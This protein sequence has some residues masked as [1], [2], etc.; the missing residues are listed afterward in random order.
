MSAIPRDPLIDYARRNWSS[1]SRVGDLANLFMRVI[2][3]SWAPV[4]AKLD[5]HLQWLAEQFTKGLENSDSQSSITDREYAAGLVAV[6]RIVNAFS[7]T[8]PRLAR[9]AAEMSNAWFRAENTANEAR[10]VQQ[11][12]ERAVQT[13]ASQREE[14]RAAFALIAATQTSQQLVLTREGQELARAAQKLA[15]EEK[16]RSEGVAE[17]AQTRSKE[18]QSTLDLVATALVVPGIVAAFFT[19]VPAL[20]GGPTWWQVTTVLVSM[21]ACALASFVG[22]RKWRSRSSAHVSD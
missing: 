14:I 5:D 13:L 12:I 7:L 22:L 17:A 11:L 8:L 10:A 6:Q 20:L 16:T 4:L 1:S 21:A 15:Q 9:P 2:V 3:E 18:V 19:A